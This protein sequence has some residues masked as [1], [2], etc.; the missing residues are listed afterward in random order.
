MNMFV[1]ALNIEFGFEISKNLYIV[2]V[3]G[4]PA[5]TVRPD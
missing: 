2:S 3:D 5:E 1:S 4:C